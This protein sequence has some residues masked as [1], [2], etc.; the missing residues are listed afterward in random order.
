[1]KI[2]K[3][4]KQAEK[5]RKW[6]RNGSGIGSGIGTGKVDKLGNPELR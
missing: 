2:S 6:K 5:R 1:L 4:G 3:N